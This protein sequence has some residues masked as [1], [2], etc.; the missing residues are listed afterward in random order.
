MKYKRKKYE[1]LKTSFIAISAKNVKEKENVAAT[2][3]SERHII[4]TG[5]INEKTSVTI[6]SFDEHIPK[7]SGRKRLAMTTGTTTEKPAVTSGTE[8]HHTVITGS[9]NEKTTV[10]IGS[11]TEKQI[12]TSGS[13]T[14]GSTTVISI[15]ATASTT[16]NQ[17]MTSGRK[18]HGITTESAT[19]QSAVTS[20]SENHHTMTT[21]SDSAQTTGAIASAAEK[22]VMNIGSMA[23]EYATLNSIVAIASTSEKS[24]TTSRRKEHVKSMPS[25]STT[26]KPPV[27]AVSA[28]EIPSLTAVSA[29]EKPSRTSGSKKLMLLLLGPPN[30]DRAPF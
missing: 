12:V 8:N 30:I 1:E 3:F 23:T 25:E 6:A 4:S 10:A 11:T 19:E 28:T 2:V 18:R 27:T 5:S 20:G 16:K 9:A 29:T 14:T 21:G 17:P 26:E 24:A 13:W 15:V 22:P 7:S